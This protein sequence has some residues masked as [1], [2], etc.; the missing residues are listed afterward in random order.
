[1]QSSVG[2]NM[3]RHLQIRFD[4]FL[5][6]YNI[7]IKGIYHTLSIVNVQTLYGLSYI[8]M[9]QYLYLGIVCTHKIFLGSSYNFVSHQLYGNNLPL[10][11][12]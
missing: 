1:M 11:W 4:T 7:K 9:T 12:N 8:S 3:N 2:S 10:T 5:L 6:Q